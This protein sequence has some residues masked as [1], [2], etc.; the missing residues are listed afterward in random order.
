MPE[1]RDP[2]LLIL[3]IADH[4]IV[5]QSMSAI[6]EEKESFTCYTTA[7]YG[8]GKKLLLKLVETDSDFRDCVT[9]FNKPDGTAEE[10]QNAGE[11]P[12]LFAYIFPFIS[13]IFVHFTCTIYI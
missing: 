11:R 5:S 13:H 3:V 1:P 12:F 6:Q 4:T 10:I 7:I 9:I 2:Y 8:K